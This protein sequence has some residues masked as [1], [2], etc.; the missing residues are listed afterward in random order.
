MLF[1]VG[2]ILMCAALY[3]LLVGNRVSVLLVFSCSRFHKQFF[4]LLYYVLYHYSLSCHIIYRNNIVSVCYS[5]QC[6]LLTYN[7]EHVHVTDC[8]KMFVIFRCT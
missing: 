8:N 5:I 1:N 2:V 7:Y 4:V 6:C 3:V